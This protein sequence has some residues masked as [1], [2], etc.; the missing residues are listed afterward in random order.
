MNRASERRPDLA[1]QYLCPS[2]RARL[3]RCLVLD[4][5]ILDEASAIINDAA[6][7]LDDECRFSSADMVK[8]APPAVARAVLLLL[9]RNVGGHTGRC[10]PVPLGLP[11]GGWLHFDP[12]PAE[13][14]TDTKRGKGLLEAA[15]LV[16][17]EPEA[18]T[19]RLVMEEVGRAFLFAWADEVSVR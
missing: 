19:I 3:A 12:R 17:G 13:W 11:C 6:N 2:E 14:A 1:G 5:E 9:A 8:A 18:V 10:G 16:T 4:S 7:V 15:S